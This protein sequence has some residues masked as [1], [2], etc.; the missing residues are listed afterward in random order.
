MKVIGIIAEYNPFHNG[1]AFQIA[2]IRR[3][4]GADYILAVM[5]GDFVQRGAPAIAGKHVRT[6][7]ALLSG[8]DLVLEL[9]ALWATS[10]A[11]SFA[12]AGVTLLE[13]TGCTDGI[14]F[15]AETADLPLLSAVADILSDEPETFR[16]ALAPGLKRGDSFPKARA[17]ALS[18]TCGCGSPASPETL[19][20]LLATPNNILALE[21]LKALRRRGSALTPYPVRRTGAGYHDTR[22]AGGDGP[23]A[24]ASAIRRLLLSCPQI[25]DSINGGSGLTAEGSFSDISDSDPVIVRARLLRDAMPLPAYTALTEHLKAYPPM[26][27]DDFSSILGYLLLQCD[28]ATLSA[29][30]DCSP[31]IANRIWN[32]RF[33]FQSFTR[34]CSAIKSRNLTYTRISRVLLHLILGITDRDYALGRELDYIPFLRILG[35]RKSAA[36]LLSRLKETSAVPVIAK[37]ADTRRILAASEKQTAGT[38]YLPAGHAG[39]LL[40]TDIFAGELYRQVQSAKTAAVFRHTGSPPGLS[41]SE[42]SEKIVIVP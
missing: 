6:R 29:V 19:Q 24:S 36:P 38:S 35:F 4:T 13:K 20:N 39:R 31:D 2:E 37:L 28:P 1:H 14:C 40:R 5:S 25:R 11:E 30:G 34:F 27:A 41:G 10:P 22:F 16:R 26:D 33:H 9:P 8:A 12:M 23:T 18:S 32:H 21:Y 17:D 15:G 7:I 3:K 42:Y